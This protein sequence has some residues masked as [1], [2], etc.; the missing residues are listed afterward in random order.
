MYLSPLAE[1]KPERK[2]D[3]LSLQPFSDKLSWASQPGHPRSRD[4]PSLRVVM[5]SFN[6]GLQLHLTL[7]PHTHTH[8]SAPSAIACWVKK[9]DT[10]PNGAERDM[11]KE[12]VR[13]KGRKAGETQKAEREQ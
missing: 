1:K 11:G 9:T 6:P 7:R 4:A 2:G 8:L 12:V 13:E 5:C 3:W 10:H